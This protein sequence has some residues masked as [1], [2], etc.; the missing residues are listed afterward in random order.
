MAGVAVEMFR[1]PVN[2]RNCAGFKFQ[3]SLFPCQH[4]FLIDV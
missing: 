2:L 1:K 4:N 3:V